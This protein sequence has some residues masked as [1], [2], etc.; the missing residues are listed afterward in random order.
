M[1]RPREDELPAEQLPE[2]LRSGW[3]LGPH[4]DSELPV[5]FHLDGDVGVESSAEPVDVGSLQFGSQVL[6]KKS[7]AVHDASVNREYIASER[8]IHDGLLKQAEAA[9]KTV[10]EIWK[11]E[12]RIAPVAFTWPAETIRTDAG[13]LHEG[14]CVLDLPAAGEARD[15]ALRA[16]VQRT[17]AYAL[18]LIEQHREEVLVIL[19]SKH[20]ARCWKIP[21]ASHGDVV[22]LERAQ[23]QVDAMHVGLLWSPTDRG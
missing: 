3:E 14:I 12:G 9:V 5:R 19:E 7:S 13:E 16:L 22:I 4:H 6:Q 23:V 11:K 20:G 8:F 15:A 1:V 21:I 17:K 10:Y 18:L 2:A